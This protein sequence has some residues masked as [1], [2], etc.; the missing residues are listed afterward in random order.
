VD[1]ATSAIRY[2][3]AA[4]DQTNLFTIDS[5]SGVIS[6][7]TA[8]AQ[9]VSRLAGVGTLPEY[10]L[11]VNATDAVG[12]VSTTEVVTVNVNMAVQTGG[13]TASLPGSMS[14]WS[15][16]PS[17]NQTFVLTNHDDPSIQVS[18]PYSV[19]TLNF[20]GGDSV[21]LANNGS[22][23]TVTYAAG[24]ASS[25]TITIAPGTSE[26][27]LTVISAAGATVEGATSSTDG[28]KM[29][30]TVDIENLNSVFGG[31]STDGHITVHSTFGDTVV[32]DVELVQFSNATVRIVGAGGYATL[33]AASAAANS[34][35]VIYVTHSSLA[36][37]TAGVINHDNLTIYIASGENA[38]MTLSS[39]WC[40]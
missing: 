22:I 36:N 11:H 13:I 14:N 31:V 19:R 34:G 40:S 5:I 10:T 17:T 28:V 38:D 35:D 37:G 27:T 18:L 39:S 3:L 32:R 15:I 25:H 30:T 9:A 12:G 20:T 4:G 7:T 2:S 26:G 6:L 1:G 8:G 23:G 29:N 33:S 24:T 16:A 21:T